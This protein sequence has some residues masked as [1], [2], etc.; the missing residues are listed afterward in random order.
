MTM[1]QSNDEL[2]L[3]AAIG[4]FI[5]KFSHLNSM[6]EFLTASIIA[7]NGD[8]SSHRRASAA[9]V[10]LTAQPLVDSFFSVLTEARDIPWSQ[11]DKEILK[12]FRKELNPLI[13]ERNRIAHD[14]WSLGHPNRPRP[15]DDAWERIRFSKSATSGY[16]SSATP[17][18]ADQLNRLSEKAVRLNSVI[19]TLALAG[20]TGDSHAPSES[21]HII[22]GPDGRRVEEKK[23]ANQ[24]I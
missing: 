22:E 13:A 24:K 21:F 20:I 2:L 7:K 9:V 1:A 18:S 17:I 10:G 11:T 12:E 16:L 15:S 14:V 23:A 6:F 4:E 5:V 3:Y 8:K 19:R